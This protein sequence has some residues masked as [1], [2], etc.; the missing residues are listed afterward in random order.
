MEKKEAIREW[1]LDIALKALV[2]KYGEV[3]TSA[4]EA[5]GYAEKLEKYIT[6]K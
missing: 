5:I 4:E 2:G 6:S 1:C 3:P